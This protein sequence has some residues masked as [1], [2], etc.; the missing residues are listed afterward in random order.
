MIAFDIKGF[1][2][3]LTFGFFFVAA[4]TTLND[5]TAG[6]L[7]LLFCIAH[8]LGHIVAMKLFGVRICGLSFYGAGIKISSDGL[9][10]CRPLKKAAVLF[11]GVAVNFALAAALPGLP[12]LI[13]ICLG[14]FN[15][16]PLEYF[17][18]GALIEMAFGNGVLTRLLSYMTYAALAALLVYAAV[19]LPGSVSV[20]SLIT[21]CF[22]AFSSVLDS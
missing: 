9:A 17:D 22:I 10:V 14:V 19:T 16:L 8:E 6:T 7:S 1:R 13:N 11:A 12:R 20:S 4:M 18:G 15:L 5:N 3:S 21:L 2:V